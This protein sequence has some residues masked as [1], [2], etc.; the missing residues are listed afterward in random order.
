MPNAVQWQG[1]WTSRGNVLSTELNSLADAGYSAVGTEV[2]NSTNLDTFGKLELNLDFVATPT[3]GDLVYVYAVYAPDGTNYQGTN[4]SVLQRNLIAVIPIEGTGTAQRVM[5]D[6]F[7]LEPAKVKF[8][9]RNEG[10]AALEASGSTVELF[11][12]N[13]EVQ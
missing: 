1:A 2:D 8:R 7:E 11:T 4:T 12:N 9:L 10:G 3:S 5:S 13:L 6:V